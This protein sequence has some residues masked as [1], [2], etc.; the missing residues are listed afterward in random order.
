MFRSFEE[1]FSHLKT[2]GRERIVVAGGEDIE[3][4]KAVKESYDYGFGKGV[5]IGYK[6]K[7]EDALKLIGS[8]EFVEKIVDISSEEEK[9]P[10][11]V[12]EVKTNGG[13]LLKGQIKTAYLLKAVLDKENGLRTDRIISDVF[14][15]EDISVS[16]K[17]VLMSDGGV[18]INPDLNALIAIIKNAVE[19][20][21][22]LGNENPKVA[23]LSAVE[24]V[25]PDMQDTLN[26]SLISKMSKR[27]QIK[28]CVIDGPLALDNAI[29]EY[30]AKKKGI[31]SEVAGNADILIV[32]NIVV[33][34]VFGKSLAYYSKFKNAHIIVGTKV[35]VMIPSRADRSDV[36]FNSIALAIASKT[37]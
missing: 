13:V 14:V 10:A 16:G 8:D 25:N 29:S 3:A 18:N 33:G 24:V 31:V 1:L 9:G 34:N 26:W 6:N 20:A 2:K 12:R 37:I 11:A 19:V 17:L 35:P 22:K 21:H 36:K 28:G 5:L 4:L 23:L 15:F 30:A 27:N 7:I 32:P